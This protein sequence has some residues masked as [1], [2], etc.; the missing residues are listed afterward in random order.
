MVLK[1]LMLLLVLEM[2]LPCFDSRRLDTAWDC[3]GRP[4]LFDQLVSKPTLFKSSIFT[5]H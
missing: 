2:Y 4:L 5:G 1:L 3:W